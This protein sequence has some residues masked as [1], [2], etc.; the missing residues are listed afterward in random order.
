[1][2]QQNLV[3]RTTDNTS[4]ID[5]KNLVAR[6]TDN[7]SARYQR[8]C[9]RKNRKNLVA[10]TANNETAKPCGKDCRQCS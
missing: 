10:R 9:V 7:A 8:E 4:T 3:A 6:T 1:M 2:K 5:N